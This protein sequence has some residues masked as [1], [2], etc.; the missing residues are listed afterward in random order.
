MKPDILETSQWPNILCIVLLVLCGQIEGTNLEDVL[1]G[2]G[3]QLSDTSGNKVRLIAD[4][5]PYAVAEQA[6][7]SEQESLRPSWKERLEEHTCR[8]VLCQAAPFSG[9]A[10]GSSWWDD[11]HFAGQ[12]ILLGRRRPQRG[13]SG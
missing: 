3:M 8:C 10:G 12:N 9:R 5:K 13:V 2:P 4:L 7:E 1:V 6:V 11:L